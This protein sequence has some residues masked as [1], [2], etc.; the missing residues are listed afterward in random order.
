MFSFCNCRKSGQVIDFFE[1]PILVYPE[2]TEIL[3]RLHKKKYKLAVASRTPEVEGA[4]ELLKIFKWTKYFKFIEIFPECK[5]AHF[6][7]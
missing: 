3:K 1:T 6:E 7:K 5:T 4:N 2:V